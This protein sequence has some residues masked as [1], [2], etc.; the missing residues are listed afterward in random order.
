MTHPARYS[1]E[2]LDVFRRAI[3]RLTRV[4]DC[5]AGTGERLGRVADDRQWFFTGTDIEM[6]FV[7]DHRVAQG[8]ATDPESYP[9]PV[10][11]GSCGEPTPTPAA[12]CRHHVLRPLTIATS[13]VYPNGIA[14]DFKSNEASRRITYRHAL[15]EA[16]G[17]PD[18]TLHSRNMGRWGFR[19]SPRLDNDARQMYWHLARSTVEHWGVAER[20]LVNVSD[21]LAGDRRVPVV[22]QWERLLVQHGWTIEERVEVRT[23]RMRNGAN[24]DARVEHEVV[25]IARPTSV[26]QKSS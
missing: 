24:A 2:V 21:F 4:H 26:N 18:A 13:P 6:P 3:P 9:W 15:V 10:A 17:D 16:T 8:D 22:A 7:V 23:K 14:D 19:S 25:L 5:Y 11:C 20:V 1:P 12:P